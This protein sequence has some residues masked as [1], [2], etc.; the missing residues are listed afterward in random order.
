MCRWRCGSQWL[1]CQRP[2]RSCASQLPF[3]DQI[4]PEAF[5][6]HKDKLCGMAAGGSA[7]KCCKGPWRRLWTKWGDEWKQI[8]LTAEDLKELCVSEGHP[9]FLM[10]SG[11]LP[12]EYEPPEKRGRAIAAMQHDGHCYMLRSA[13]SLA[14]WSTTDTV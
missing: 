6:V 5:E 10:S 9:L 2:P 3:A 7:A 8:G 11:R 4:L 12:L 1:L 13:S 14:N